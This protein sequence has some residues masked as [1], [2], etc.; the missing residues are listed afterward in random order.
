MQRIISMQFKIGIIT[1]LFSW[2]SSSFAQIPLGVYVDVDGKLNFWESEF[3]YN[4]NLTDTVCIRYSG[5]LFYSDLRNVKY[6]LLTIFEPP[7]DNEFLP[8]SM[9]P[10]KQFDDT[11]DT[12]SDERANTENLE[13]H[14]VYFWNDSSEFSD[15]TIAFICDE[16][17]DQKLNLPWMQNTNRGVG[18]SSEMEPIIQQQLNE[19]IDCNAG[20]WEEEDAFWN[21]HMD[22]SEIDSVSNQKACFDFL[23]DYWLNCS[24]NESGQL[25]SVCSYNWDSGVEILQLDYEP[26]GQVSLIRHEK[27]GGIANEYAFYYNAKAQVIEVEQCYATV[28]S[29][30]STLS[31]AYPIRTRKRFEYN[32]SGIISAIRTQMPNGEWDTV[33]IEFSPNCL[34][35]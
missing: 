16:K 35:Y 21:L 6:D 14:S 34:K 26:N 33:L 18:I 11:L 1:W 2:D 20:Y 4:G 28:G 3:N 13:W 19:Y 15:A 25:V 22:L 29:N 31:Y 12:T 17:T 7:G 30:R 9:D 5:G 24:R 27:I 10:S 32:E 23:L 8:S